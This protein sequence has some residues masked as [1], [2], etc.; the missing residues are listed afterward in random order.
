M[1][2]EAAGAIGEIIGALA[3][4]LTLAYLAIQIRQNTKAVRTSALDSA[5]SAVNSIREKLLESSELTE[6]YINGSKN[7]ESLSEAEI[8]RYRILMTNTFWSI[9]NLYSQAKY[10]ELSTS[11]WECQIHVIMRLLNTNGGKWFWKMHSKEFEDS[12]VIEID[13]I[14]ESRE[15]KS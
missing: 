6:I 13:R 9:W 5:V 2:W 4:F 14:I 12:F 11:A 8:V 7:P 15:S 3:V 10:A 1:N